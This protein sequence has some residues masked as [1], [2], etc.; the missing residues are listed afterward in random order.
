[1][2]PCWLSGM[3]V[4]LVYCEKRR[5]CVRSTDEARFFDLASST[6]IFYLPHMRIS[7]HK[8]LERIVQKYFQRCDTTNHRRIMNQQYANKSSLSSP[9][10]PAIPVPLRSSHDSSHSNPATVSPRTASMTSSPG[11]T[12]TQPPPCWDPT[13]ENKLS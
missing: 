7:G 5:S 8:N 6:R 1:M 3:S 11:S 12:R 4:A 10:R 9:Q 2:M 13:L